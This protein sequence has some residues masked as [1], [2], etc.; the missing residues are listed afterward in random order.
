MIILLLAGMLPVHVLTKLKVIVK[1]PST[2]PCIHSFIF[3]ALQQGVK[4]SVGI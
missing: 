2:V 3:F 4:Q 1:N